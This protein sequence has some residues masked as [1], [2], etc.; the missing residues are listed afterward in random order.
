MKTPERV[1]FFSWMTRVSIEL[2]VGFEEQVEDEDTNSAIYADDLDEADD[3]DEPGARVMTRMTAVPTESTE[4]YRSLAA[5]SVQIGSRSVETQEELLIDGAPAIRQ[6][7]SYRDDELELDVFRHE[8]FAQVANVVFSITC[9][10]PALRSA[11]YRTAFDYAGETARWILLPE[12]S[13]SYAHEGIRISARVPESWI[14][15]ELSDNHVRFFGPPHP[16][17][18]EYRSTFSINLGEPEGYG[19]QWFQDFCDASRVTL[20]QKLSGFELRS[21][22]RFALSSFVNIHAVW[23][24]YETESG[25]AFTQLQALGLVDRYHMYLINAAALRPLADQYLPVFDDILRS[26]RMLPAR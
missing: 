26:L 25:L 23:Y 24:S 18:D 10:A 5:A 9:L 13:A 20:E 17:Y 21:V 15:S 16:E 3:Q 11:D 1:H 8:T 7:L 6:T 12:T 4:A 14:V 2:P 22:E 19:E